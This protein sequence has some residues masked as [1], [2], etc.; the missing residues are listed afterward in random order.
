VSSDTLRFQI[1][2]YADNPVRFYCQASATIASGRVY[3]QGVLCAGGR[4]LRLY[5]RSG[6]WNL[7][8]VPNYLAGE[9]SVSARSAA[10]GDVIR[11]GESRA[12]FVSYRDPVV[13]RGCPATSTFNA[14][15]TGVV[16]WSP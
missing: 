11:A 14:T 8:T 10:L 2:E 1:H 9:L 3:G 7:F 13:P 6:N 5:T 15:Q 12:Y 4:T 16:T